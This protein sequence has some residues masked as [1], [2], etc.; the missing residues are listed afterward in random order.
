MS[1]HKITNALFI[2]SIILALFLGSCSSS[3]AVPEEQEPTQPPTAAPTEVPEPTATPLPTAVPTPSDP[4]MAPAM[5]YHSGL[6]EPVVGRVLIFGGNSKHGM[7]GDVKKVFSYDAQ[8]Q[9]WEEPR[10]FDANPAWKNAMSPAYDE[11]SGRVIIFN[12]D[13]ETWAYDVGND[14]WEL[15]APKPAPDGRCGHQMSYDSESDIVILY[16]GFKCSGPGDPIMNETW[17][18]DYN[19]DTWTAM[20]TTPSGRIYHEIVYDVESDI[21]VMWGGRPHEELDDVDV[22]AYDY[23]SDS[24]TA[25]PVEN[26]P[27]LRS[28][29]HTMEYIP[30]LDRIIIFGGVQLTSAFGGDFVTNIWEYDFNNNSWEMIE[31]DLTPPQLA[32]HVT[33]YDDQM[34]FVYLFGGSKEV[35]YSND[36]ISFEFWSYDPVNRVWS[37]LNASQ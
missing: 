21:I 7:N 18:Y 3:A 36:H 26:G 15:M 34:G 37:D 17:A 8:N 9:V 29:Y 6:Y 27:T 32:K 23:N 11:E 14:V 22:W 16:G 31:P 33:A 2:F 30:E 5:I 20:S 19:T 12:V 13:G 24:W 28:S 10:T 1:N 35:I 4:N 25:Y